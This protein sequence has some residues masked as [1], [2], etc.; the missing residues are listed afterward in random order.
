[1][2]GILRKKVY[3]MRFLFL[4]A[5]SSNIQYVRFCAALEQIDCLAERNLKLPEE[6]DCLYLLPRHTGLK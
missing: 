1:M 3:I 2:E 6:E 4:C 5:L